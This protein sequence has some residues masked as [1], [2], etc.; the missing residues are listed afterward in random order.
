MSTGTWV[1]NTKYYHGISPQPPFLLTDE[2][3]SY[4]DAV[5]GKQKP[6]YNY[7]AEEIQH[8]KEH[9][10]YCRQPFC[11]YHHLHV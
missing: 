5:K 7:I 6:L 10:F 2:E 3:V 11:H 4:A 8:A 1:I 9:P